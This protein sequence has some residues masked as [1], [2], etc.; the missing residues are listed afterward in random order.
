MIRSKIADAYARLDNFNFADPPHGSLTGL[1]DD[2]KTVLD[3]Y[4]RLKKQES[5]FKP[6]RAADLFVTGAGQ[7]CGG[8][9]GV[10]L[11]L[12]VFTWWMA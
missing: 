10:A 3:D 12:G 9:V 8:V 5:E 4:D 11:V 1:Y 2:V 6:W 7:G